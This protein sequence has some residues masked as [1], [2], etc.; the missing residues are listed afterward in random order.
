D[1]LGNQLSPD[2]LDLREFRHRS[3]RQ[4]HGDVVG[5]TDAIGYPRASVARTDEREPGPRVDGS[6]HATQEVVVAELRLGSSAF[7]AVHPAELGSTQ[8]SKKARQFPA[9]NLFQI[10]VARVADVFACTTNEGTDER[11]AFGSAP[12]PF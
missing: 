10:I 6:S 2:R 3:P 1:Q 9:R 12:L 7:V 8:V 5:L 11:L 4:L